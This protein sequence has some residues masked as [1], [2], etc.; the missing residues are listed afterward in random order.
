MDLTTHLRKEFAWSR[1]RIGALVV[2]LIVLP[3]AFGAGTLFFQHTFPENT[4]IAVVG[5]DG[6]TEDDRN[7]VVG[8]ITASKF[9]DPIRYDSRERAFA[10]LEREQVYAV[11]EVPGDLGKDG[12]TSTIVV[13]I[14]GRITP[15][16]IP[17]RALLS[18]FA[19]GI[20]RQ[21]PGE[22]TAERR[23]IGT[24]TDLPT[25]LLPV[26]L[27]VLLMLVAFTY[28]PYNV[29]NERSA[30]DRLRLESSVDAM[31]AAKFAVFVPFAFLVIL[32]VYAAGTLLGHSLQPPSLPLLGAYILAFLYLSAISV[33][34]MLLSGFS[35]LG[36]VVNVVVFF[37]LLALSNLAYPA[38]FFSA[39]GREV[40]RTMPT[41]YSMIIARSHMLKGVPA[42][43][44]ADWWGPLVGFTLV[45]FLGLK[46]SVA[47][48]ERGARA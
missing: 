30:I 36:R 42:G 46:L 48:Y 6:A 34:I 32:A 18:V 26:F 35:T 13:H 7:I 15:Y 27:M 4:P 20:D 28:V 44:F 39:W 1:H 12:T 22:V 37:A 2:L 16:R 38:G 19:V 31:L 11:I 17:S 29:A 40:A 33:S 5:V 3:A 14:D 23:V 45:T 9:S 43:T 25:Y 8:A 10:A 24:V 47:W 41:H 21:L